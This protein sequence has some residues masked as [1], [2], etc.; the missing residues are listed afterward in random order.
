M[1]TQE[2]TWFPWKAAYSVEV[3]EIDAQHKRLV[4]IINRLQDAMLQGQGRAVIDSVLNGLEAYTKT[5]FAFEEQILAKHAYPKLVSHEA[6]HRAFIG[7][8]AQLR[9]EYSAGST[10]MSG[11]VMEFMKDWLT[12][13]IMQE[14][15]AYSAH[16]VKVVGH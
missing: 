16:L 3:P 1:P 8:L 12:H 15:R 4:E 6:Q 10:T 9:A 13:H 2:K 7:K 14:D 11:Q 5:H